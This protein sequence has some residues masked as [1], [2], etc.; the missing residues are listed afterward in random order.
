MQKLKHNP[1]KASNTKHSKT[2]LE[3]YLGLVA[4]YNTRPGNEV[5]LFYNTSACVYE[6]TGEKVNVEMTLGPDYM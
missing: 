2:K 4:F 6:Q 1:E 5:S 3:N